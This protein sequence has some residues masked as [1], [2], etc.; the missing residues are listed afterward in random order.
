MDLYDATLLLLGVA[1]L[2]AALLPRVLAD[3]PLSLPIVYLAVGFVL[4]S[5]PTGIDL[6]DP[7]EYPDHTERLAEVAVVVSLMAA[8]LQLDR[9]PG[10]RAWAPTWRL[11]AITM[12]LTIAG[13]ALGGYWLVGLTPAAALLLGAVLAPTDPVLASDVQTGGRAPGARTRPA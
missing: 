9:R 7:G 1:A 13:V 2:G 5:L 12:P 3:R 4:F 10:L 8:G 6:P 11:L